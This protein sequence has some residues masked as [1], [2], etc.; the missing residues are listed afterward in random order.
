MFSSLWDVVGGGFYLGRE[1]LFLFVLVC[2]F[3]I[4]YF[5]MLVSLLSFF[6]GYVKI[7]VNRGD[8]CLVNLGLSLWFICFG[9]G[10]CKGKFMC[11]ELLFFFV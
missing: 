4:I 9:V 11:W 6:V 3:L 10:I 5:L 7:K 8:F 2:V 1:G